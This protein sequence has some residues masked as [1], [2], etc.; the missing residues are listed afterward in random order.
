[1]VLVVGVEPNRGQLITKLADAYLV[2][3][4]LYQ[5]VN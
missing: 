1:M 3:V 4:L 2:I 5:F